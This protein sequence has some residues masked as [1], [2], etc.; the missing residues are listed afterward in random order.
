[1][2][3][4]K[5]CLTQGWIFKAVV[6]GFLI[7]SLDLS[8]LNAQATHKAPTLKTTTAL[9]YNV[10]AIHSSK[11][12]AANWSINEVGDTLSV[13]NAS[14]R[15]MIAEAYSIRED[16][17]VG[18]P[19]WANTNHYD[20]Q[21]KILGADPDTLKTVT[22]IQHRAML[23]ALLA[24]RFQLTVHPKTMERPVYELRVE[25]NGVKLRP[26]ATMSLNAGT[27]KSTF[28]GAAPGSLNTH[29]SGTEAELI[30]HAVSME[31]VAFVLSMPV[32]RSVVDR[33]G[34]SGVYD[35]DLTWNPHDDSTNVGTED[36]PGLFTALNEQ[37]GLKLVAAR[38]PVQTIA[39]DDVHLPTEN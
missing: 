33:T 12:D 36:K 19:S 20:I 3:T 1:M 15:E 27:D 37:L 10:A 21:G 25:P 14:I 16:L 32:N 30:G 31:K 22:D 5:Q 18:L 28:H 24:D 35:I 13:H 11:D 7:V 4:C 8:L 29:F 39:V 26:V 34:L 38:G 2:D 23:Q 6:G 9:A 17:V